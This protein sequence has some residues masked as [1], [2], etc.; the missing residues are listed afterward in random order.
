ML[1]EGGLD[2]ETFGSAIAAIVRSAHAQ[3]LLIDDVLDMSRIIAG[4]MQIDPQPVDLGD[5]VQA[6]MRTVQPAADAKGVMLEMQRRPGA[7]L[8]TGDP[9]RLQQIVWNLLSNAIKFTPRGGEVV[10]RIEQ[11]GSFVRLSVRDS[12][13]GIG[14]EFLPHVFE[15]FRQA[16]NVTTRTYGGLGLGL[17]IARQLAELHGGNISA[18]SEGE[19]KGA[20]FVIEL[21][22]RA[23]RTVDAAHAASLE[24]FTWRPANVQSDAAY[25]SLAGVRVLVVDDQADARALIK[26]VLRRCGAEVTTA[27]SVSDAVGRLEG[28]VAD[29][30]V[31]D[32]A[33]PEADGF[34]LIRHIRETR[35]LTI[36]VIAMTAFGHPAD[37]EKILAAGFT[38]YLKKPVE[39]I[40]L[41]RELHAVLQRSRSESA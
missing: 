37:Q 34:D 1:E 4:K 15:P 16:E 41:A 21:P 22:V 8:V 28:G 19:G 12:G 27:A 5:V 31:S 7:S 13:K 10:T 18:Q 29:I 14:P 32:I 40:D 26:T 2:D 39:P 23:V 24:R 6:A 35:K 20:T 30:V 25:P 11:S 17:A 38:R 9:N 3:A 36:P 33:M